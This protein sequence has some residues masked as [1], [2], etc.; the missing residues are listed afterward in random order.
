MKAIVNEAL[1]ECQSRK[2]AIKLIKRKM[3]IAFQGKIVNIIQ[4]FKV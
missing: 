4:K 1:T 3:R 2:G